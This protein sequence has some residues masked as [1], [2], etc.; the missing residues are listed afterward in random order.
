MS[1]TVDREDLKRELQQVRT[2]GLGKLRTLKVPLLEGLAEAAAK[3]PSDDT[4]AK[5]EQLIGDAIA[6]LDGLH[7]EAAGCLFGTV[8]GLRHVKVRLR[9]ERA[10]RVLGQS[11]ETFRTRHMKSLEYEVVD[12][13]LLLVKQRNLP[14]PDEPPGSSDHPIGED[15]L[16][17]TATIYVNVIHDLP[18]P[19]KRYEIKLEGNLRAWYLGYLKA[20]ADRDLMPTTNLVVNAAFDD[21]RFSEQIN[22]PQVIT[23]QFRER[24]HFEEWVT[25]CYGHTA[26]GFIQEICRL[27]VQY[28]YEY[29]PDPE[30]IGD[31][32]SQVLCEA[33]Y[34]PDLKT[35]TFFNAIYCPDRAMSV[36]I[37]LPTDGLRHRYETHMASSPNET[38]GWD[39]EP[40]TYLGYL[41]MYVDY[42]I[43]AGRENLVKLVLPM[44]IATWLEAGRNIEEYEEQEFFRLGQWALR[45]AP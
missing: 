12:A 9:Q 35:R 5:V 27:S 3:N 34:E 36:P 44:L 7:V 39:H 33:W 24:A 8:S 26:A 41:A 17:P 30:N 1:E 23:W 14:A 21:P 32:I 15:S 38:N 10:G 22:D 6:C 45:Y 37:T 13:I 42:L 11:G 20:R 16:N 18:G 29:Y 4:P 28:G 25:R 19:G 43:F 40:M 2:R 31:V